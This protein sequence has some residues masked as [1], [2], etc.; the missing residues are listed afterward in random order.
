[1]NHYQVGLKKPAFTTK[2]H[3]ELVNFTQANDSLEDMDF[4]QDLDEGRN[5]YRSS[6]GGA[7]LRNY[8]SSGYSASGKV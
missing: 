7:S 5:N 6:T 1:M 8:K 3:Q 2:S 4:Q